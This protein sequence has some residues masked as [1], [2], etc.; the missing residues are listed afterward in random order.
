[1]PERNVKID[2]E[3][4]DRLEK[5]NVCKA[6]ADMIQDGR[7]EGKQEGFANGRISVLSTFIQSGKATVKEAAA[8]MGMT[9]EEFIEKSKTIS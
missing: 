2:N 1:M 3:E 9:Q 5:V 6:I 8:I 7:D 4:V